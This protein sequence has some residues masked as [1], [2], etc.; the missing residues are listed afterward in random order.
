MIKRVNGRMITR[1]ELIARV[2]ASVNTPRGED[3]DSAPPKWYQQDVEQGVKCIFKNIIDVL[4]EGGRAD[5]RGLGSFS[6]RTRRPRMLRNPRTGQPVYLT[7]K[8]V[9]HFKPGK[10]LR[11]KVNASRFG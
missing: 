7:G 11:E 9:P 10:A 3:D 6:L 8:S 5:I 4:S 2:A 1:A